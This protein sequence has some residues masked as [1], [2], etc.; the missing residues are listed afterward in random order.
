VSVEWALPAS[1]GDADVE[2]Y[3][4]LMK[5]EYE[6]SYKEIY[7]GLSRSYKATLL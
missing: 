7:S 3:T 6:A 4:L 2:Y 5:A 1:D